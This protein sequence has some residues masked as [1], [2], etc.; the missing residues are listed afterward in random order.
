MEM[1]GDDYNDG[2]LLLKLETQIMDVGNKP[3]LLTEIIYAFIWN[4]GMGSAIFLMIWSRR[5]WKS[6]S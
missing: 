3:V 4:K 2:K 1:Y 5:E 6:R